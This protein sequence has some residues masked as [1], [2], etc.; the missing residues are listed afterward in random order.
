MLRIFAETDTMSRR[1]G[2]WVPPAMERNGPST[3]SLLCEVRGCPL[4]IDFIKSVSG[5]KRRE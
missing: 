4:Q 1:R 3:G 2:G 5:R